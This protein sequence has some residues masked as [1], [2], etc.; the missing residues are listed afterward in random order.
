MPIRARA[1]AGSVR[2]SEP[3]N[4]IEP[5]LTGRRPMMHF[6]RVVFPIPFRPIRHIRDPSGTLKSTSHRMWLP[7]Y[8]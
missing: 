3:S 5:E 8:D 1:S 6:S 4:F 7:P 2:R